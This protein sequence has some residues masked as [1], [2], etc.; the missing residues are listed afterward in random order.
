MALIPKCYEQKKKTRKRK[1]ERLEE[2]GEISN[3][4]ENE[5]DNYIALQNQFRYY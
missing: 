2:W 5:I 1:L 3:P 4:I